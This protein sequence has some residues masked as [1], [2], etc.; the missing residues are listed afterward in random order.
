MK[1]LVIE[2]ELRA[3][4]YLKQGLSENGYV[5]EVEQTALMVCTLRP[6]ATT[7]R[8]ATILGKNR[9]VF[10]LRVACE[11]AQGV[12]L[13]LVLFSLVTRS[14]QAF[15][16]LLD[17]SPNGNVWLKRLLDVSPTWNR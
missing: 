6:M 12:S 1:L 2:G 14:F 3:S 5:V 4:E 15:N 10:M 9:C 7:Y 8:A 11:C 17:A 13:D 16:A